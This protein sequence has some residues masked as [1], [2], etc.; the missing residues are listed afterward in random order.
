[1]DDVLALLEDHPHFAMPGDSTIEVSEFL[2]LPGMD[3]T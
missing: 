3:G 1:M 2:S